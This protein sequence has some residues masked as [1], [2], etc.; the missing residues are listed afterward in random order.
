MGGGDDYIIIVCVSMWGRNFSK[1]GKI[2]LASDILNL[3]YPKN[4]KQAIGIYLKVN[5]LA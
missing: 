1:E 5:A 4:V 3:R 2:S